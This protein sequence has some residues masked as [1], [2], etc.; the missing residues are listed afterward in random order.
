[1]RHDRSVV[2]GGGS[3][4]PPSAPPAVPPIIINP[5]CYHSPQPAI[6]PFVIPLRPPVLPPRLPG[7]RADEALPA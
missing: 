3:K 7:I 5:F 4:G 2:A 6:D 1:M